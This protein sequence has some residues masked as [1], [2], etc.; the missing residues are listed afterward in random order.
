MGGGNISGDGGGNINEG[1]EVDLT[2]DLDRFPNEDMGDVVVGVLYVGVPILKVVDIGE[3]CGVSFP[4][5]TS[6]KNLTCCRINTHVINHIK[7]KQ[8]LNINR[9][10]SARP[11]NSKTLIIIFLM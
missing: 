10:N 4:T 3:H 1:R 6:L 9:A 8:V 2:L 5:T 7:D 11:I